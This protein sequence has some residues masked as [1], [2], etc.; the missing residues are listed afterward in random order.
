MKTLVN[1]SKLFVPIL[2]EIL[3]FAIKQALQ[4]SD[5]LNNLNIT[6]PCSQTLIK[7]VGIRCAHRIPEILE[8][9]MLMSPNDGHPQ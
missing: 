1:V 6:I 3:S 9:G 4:Q 7:G 5:C 8:S 2:G